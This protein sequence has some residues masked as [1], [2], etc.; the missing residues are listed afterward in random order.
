MVRTEKDG[1]K[2][3]Y[4]IYLNSIDRIKNNI[5][6]FCVTT[7]D[8]ANNYGNTKHKVKLKIMGKPNINYD[9]K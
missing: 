2:D 6:T 7:E 8:K 9:D 3:L 5:S 4:L 1:N